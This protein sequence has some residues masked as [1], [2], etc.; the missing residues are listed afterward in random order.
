MSTASELT[1]DWKDKLLGEA[2]RQGPAF[3]IL[4]L[5]LFGCWKLGN[6]LVTVG[7]PAH[8]E[9]I[10][11]GYREIQDS[12]GKNLERV[13]TAFESEQQRSKEVVELVS[14]LIENQQL[15]RENRDLL[16]QF[17]RQHQPATR[18]NANP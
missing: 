17:V 1:P 8:L 10:K 14:D 18:P 6:H 5:L 16:L 9:Q 7:I 4:L 15:L 2:I 3:L 13:V 11:Q 12:H